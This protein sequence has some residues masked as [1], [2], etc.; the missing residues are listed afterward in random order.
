[1]SLYYFWQGWQLSVGYRPSTARRQVTG[2]SP[3][4]SDPTTF[5]LLSFVLAGLFLGLSQYTYLPARLL[6]LLFGLL[7]ILW[8]FQARRQIRGQDELNQ[9]RYA[10]L[11]RFWFG[12]LITAGVALLVFAPL[13][14]Y[15]LANPASFS[16]RTG[17][18]AFSADSPV[19]LA[20]HL[21]R[22]VTLFLGAGHELYRHHLPGRAM[23][24]WLEIPFFWLGLIFLLRPKFLRYPETQLILVGLV[25]MWLPAILASPP[26][27]SLRPIGIMPFYYL[28]VTIGLWLTTRLLAGAFNRDRSGSTRPYAAGS[29][30]ISRFSRI[31]VPL[32]VAGV[33]VLNGLVNTVDYV[34]RWSSHPEVYKEFN[35]PLVDLVRHIS[36]LAR[37]E[38]VII[39]FHVYAHPTTRYLLHDTFSELQAGKPRS[40]DTG[41]PVNML[42]VPDKFQLLYVGNIPVSPALVWLTRDET[43][44]GTAYVSRPPRAA[45]QAELN[46][47]LASIQP[48]AEPF[49]DDLGRN[50]GYFLPLS[51]HDRPATAGLAPI[52]NLFDTAPLRTTDLN[53]ANLVK[54]AGYDVTPQ[55]ARPG[56]QL[57]LNLYWQSLT[58]SSF[59]Y[60]LF[61]QIVDAAGQPLN[62]WEGDAFS[63]DMYRWR[64][65]RILPS[66]HTL[67]IGPDTPPGPYLI[68]LGFFDR[69]TG[70]RLPLRT[71]GT[72]VETTGDGKASPDQVYLGL[73]YV[74]PDGAD[75]R[76]PAEPILA[77]F[78]NA[79]QLV[80]TTL[81]DISGSRL[82]PSPAAGPDQ[83]EVTFHWE[84]LQPTDK[85]YTVFL[86]LL[87]EQ[88]ELISSWD[89][90]PL[91][92][93]YPTQLWSPGEVVVDTFVLPLP[94]GGL[95]PGKYRLI[96]GFYDFDT[97]QRLPLVGAGDAVELAEF[98]VD[99]R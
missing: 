14:L 3:P 6:P 13:G 98:V 84:V 75:P 39:P 87:N 57:R 50:I 12:I 28:I 68:R 1:L 48:E 5:P 69:Q 32:L 42:V 76:L 72:L 53:W 49:L 30:T 10:G 95:V 24:G 44:Q 4:A 7:A 31:A 17:D 71:D 99:R 90:E 8:T 60:R 38:D 63:E 18:V 96:T 59:D 62:Q 73:F 55:V 78:A 92:G 82:S 80:G 21:L 91:G 88:D 77:N 79:I 2:S 15:F 46:A 35:G 61:L 47:L 58:D 11:K 74:S 83:L 89:S 66:Q 65:G 41:R 97:G 52:S 19:N 20:D 85:P 64:P 9:D 29:G 37:T 36:D 67:W 81:P 22:A 16:A 40:G 25:V 23:L 33:V 51:G 45:E 86:Q 94:E 26:V 56:Q 54:L 70:E 43:G 34:R 27:H 93:L